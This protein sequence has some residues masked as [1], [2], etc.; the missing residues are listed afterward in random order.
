[1]NRLAFAAVLL[2]WGGQAAAQSASEYN[3]RGHRLYQK[4]DY[5]NALKLF[6]KLKSRHFS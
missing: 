3:K 6:Q 5:A 4:K 1:M 2:V